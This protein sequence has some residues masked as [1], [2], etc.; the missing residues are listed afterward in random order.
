MEVIEQTIAGE[1]DGVACSQS[2]G[3]ADF[4]FHFGGADDVRNQVAVLVVHR[5][6]LIEEPRLGHYVLIHAGYAIQQ[7]DEEQARETL[8]LLEELAAEVG[9]I[10]GEAGRDD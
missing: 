9:D 8:A 6:S 4:D 3:W 1:K 7:L 5:L 2:D 10:G